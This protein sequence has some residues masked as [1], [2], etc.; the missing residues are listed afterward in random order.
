MCTVKNFTAVG[1]AR[2]VFFSLRAS[3]A[4]S[5]TLM[6]TRVYAGALLDASSFPTLE[7]A[8]DI[9]F[10]TAVKVKLLNHYLTS[11]SGSPIVVHTGH[12]ANMSTIKSHTSHVSFTRSAWFSTCF[13]TRVRAFWVCSVARFFAFHVSRP[14]KSGRVASIKL[15]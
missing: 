14:M 15:V 13:I 5:L 1:R 8:L 3:G 9:K 7:I 4:L 12:D 2:R 6:T 10:M 11:K